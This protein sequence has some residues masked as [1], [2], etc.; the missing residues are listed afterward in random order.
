MI[1]RER[2][3]KLGH[4][5][6]SL[7]RYLARKCF[8]AFEAIG[9]HVLGDHFYEPVPNLREIA[10]TYRDDVPSLPHGLDADFGELEAAHLDRIARFGGTFA[11]DVSRRGYRPDNPYFRAAD[12]LSLYAYVRARGV[13]RVVEVG[14]GFSSLVSLAA[15]GRNA[16]E[17]GSEVSFTSI[18]PHDRLLSQGNLCRGV[19]ASVIARPVQEVEAG[20]LLGMLGPGTLLFV[21]SSHVFKQGS[22]VAYLMREIYP[23]MPQ[24][25]HLHVH[26]VYL[27][28]PWPKANLLKRKWFWNEQDH[29]ESL[30][31]FCDA[32]RLT[33]PV[34]WLCRDSARVRETISAIA[35]APF[36]A[37]VSLY[38]ERTAE[39]D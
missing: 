13:T 34:Y 16:E 38:L 7:Q 10:R 20:V 23:R 33:L 12:A 35:P 15:L 19:E 36:E 39:R 27:P 30:L 14:Q 2:L 4:E 9:L 37:G 22:D 18:D 11:D 29:L 31:A 26:D 17:S 24:G 21:D 1:D 3:Y 28:Y 8:R 32:F 6:N 5:R 25:S